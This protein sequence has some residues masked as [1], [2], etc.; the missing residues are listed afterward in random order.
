MNRLGL[1]CCSVLL[2]CAG[3][4]GRTPGA[5]APADLPRAATPASDN[6]ASWQVGHDIAA[7]TVVIDGVEHRVPEDLA[8]SKREMDQVAADIEEK[9]DQAQ[10]ERLARFKD[11]DN[12]P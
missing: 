4:Q 7:E 5:Q 3:C 2:A 1:L 6:S 8:A 9:M 10:A 11:P 12:Q